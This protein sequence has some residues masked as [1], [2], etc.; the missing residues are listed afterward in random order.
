MQS[1]ANPSQWISLFN[2]VKTGNFRHFGLKHAIS[3]VISSRFQS[4]ARDFP[5]TKNREI[6]PVSGNFISLLRLIREASACAG[7]GTT[8]HCSHRV[9]V[10]RDRASTGPTAYTFTRKLELLLGGIY[11]CGNGFFRH[12]TARTG[13]GFVFDPNTV[14]EISIGGISLDTEQ[15]QNAQ[16]RG[17]YAPYLGG[18]N[19][20]STLSARFTC[21]T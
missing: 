18:G 15:A 21:T 8:S 12:G 10:P 3:T 5:K 2:R 19:H 4:V 16:H 11:G 9:G 6:K 14:G 13:H 17:G 7:V 20:H 1:G